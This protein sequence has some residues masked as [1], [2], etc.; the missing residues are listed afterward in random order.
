MQGQ[1]YTSWMLGDP[2]DVSPKNVQSGIVLAGGAT[3]NDEAMRWMLERGDGGDVVVIRASGSDGYN[4]YFFSELGVEVNSVQTIRFEEPLSTWDTYVINQIRNAEVLFIAGGDQ[5]DYFRLWKDSPIASSINYLINEKAAMVGGTSAGMAILGNIYYT[6]S[7]GSLTSEEALA[8]PFH[9]NFDILGKDDFVLAPVLQDVV[10][11]T[12]Y[13]QRDRAGRHV[14]FLA[15][16]LYDFGIAPKGIAANEFVAIGIDENNIAHIFGEYPEYP[17]DA[18]YFLQT[19]CQEHPGPEVYE[20]NTPLHWVRGRSAVQ[21]FKVNAVSGGLNT[22]DLNDWQTGEGEWQNWYVVNGELIRDN[23]GTGD[24][25]QIIS[26]TEDY[27]NIT[28][29]IFPNPF[30][31]QLFI[32][33]TSGGDVVK[34]Y[35]TFGEKLFTKSLHPAETS[36]H[37]SHLPVGM[38]VV[39]INDKVWKVWKR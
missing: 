34:I 33:N 24:C 39:R 18:A 36:L 16:A 17:E 8:N 4:N 35:S 14:G 12:H 22:F 30:V 28:V 25:T 19:N 26:S 31:D 15:K 38:Y 21:V 5:Y 11:D 6:P 1:G 13:D 37:L 7:A 10:T 2:E 20:S 32:E 3:D 9:E 29:N 27:E 23:Q